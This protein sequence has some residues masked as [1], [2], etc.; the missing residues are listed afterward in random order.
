MAKK[1][2]LSEKVDKRTRARVWCGEYQT[3]YPTRKA[4]RHISYNKTKEDLELQ[5]Q[6]AR[7]RWGTGIYA[8]LRKEPTVQ[9]VVLP[10]AEGQPLIT[11][12]DNGEKNT[13][14]GEF[15]WA[16]Y[17]DQ[18]SKTKLSESSKASTY[19][20]LNTHLVPSFGVR[21][22][23]DITVSE[24]QDFLYEF[25]GKSY[26][27]AS[28]MMMTIKQFFKFAESKKL[29]DH[30]ILSQL[31]TLK[32]PRTTQGE[33]RALTEAEQRIMLSLGSTHKEGLFLIILYWLGLRRGEALGL[34]WSDFNFADKVVHV[35]RDVDFKA[36][37][38]Q[39]LGELKTE[40]A[41]RFI[42]VTP[43]LMKAL[44]LIKPEAAILS[45]ETRKGTDFLFKGTQSEM[46]LCESSYKRMWERLMIAAYDMDP[47]IEAVLIESGSNK[48]KWRSIL[49]PHYFR[50]NFATMLC[51]MGVKPEEAIAWMGHEDSQMIRKVYAHRTE[52]AQAKNAAIFAQGAEEHIEYLNRDN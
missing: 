34:R 12:N 11:V 51:D 52:K 32:M 16:W 48:G 5:T 31:Y 38:K 42:P 14:F 8:S 19:A 26:S 22:I 41:Y 40:A 46:P 10:M 35:Q 47:S 43:Q 25:E 1:K 45:E 2:K 49:T 13:T 23:R 3:D 33:R 15:A 24:L 17:H 21:I 36:D 30:E 37:S 50:H 20:W 27:L 29:V 44:E 9:A 39:K 6:M 4:Y 28:K 18:I 7:E